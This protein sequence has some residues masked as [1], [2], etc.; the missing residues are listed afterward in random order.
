[1]QALYLAAGYP[2]R[3][4]GWVSESQAQELK[5]VPLVV[6][7]D[8]LPSPVS[9]FAHYVLPGATFAEKE[10]T[11]V[12]HAGLAQALQWG[13]TPTGECRGDGQVFLDLLQR[14]GLV[15]A[16]TLRK[17]LAEEVKYFAPLAGGELGEYG[18]PLEQAK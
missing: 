6:C 11:F 12:N 10:G 17:E 14:R 5:K 18:I 8:I 2:P 13:V 7:H 9:A 3:P 4:G 1:M 15:H 16:P